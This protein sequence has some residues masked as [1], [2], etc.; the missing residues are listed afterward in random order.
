MSEGADQVVDNNSLVGL[1][2]QL[3]EVPDPAPVSMMPQT[4]GWLVLLA[5]V[6]ALMTWR[7][8][9]FW[10]HYQA[11]AYRR[12]A[13]REL[14]VAGDD[15]VAISIIL[16]R[17]ALVA[18]G[19]RRVAALSGAAWVGFL[20]ETGRGAWDQ[21]A[22]AMAAYQEAPSAADPNVTVAARDWVKTHK[23]REAGDV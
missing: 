12:A 2:N 22:L 15:P 8:W 18:Y 1:L 20:Q 6:L 10:Q 11:N 13:L 5:L 7:G 3:V 16:K 21:T 4:V 19:R 23:G 14:R 17:A 9:R